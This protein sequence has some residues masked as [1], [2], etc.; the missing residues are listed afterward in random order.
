[1][2]CL[3]RRTILIKWGLA[4]FSVQL[5]SERPE[6][7]GGTTTTRRR[8]RDSPEQIVRKLQDADAMLDTGK[9]LAS[10][11]PLEVSEAKLHRWRNEYG[12]MASLWVY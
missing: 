2:G 7:P 6:G 3:H 1:M 4:I 12:G 9:E 10:V 8:K 5:E 11:L